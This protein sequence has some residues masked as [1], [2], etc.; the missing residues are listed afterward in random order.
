LKDVF[1]QYG[2]IYEKSNILF[3]DEGQYHSKVNNEENYLK[4]TSSWTFDGSY[5]RDKNI[6]TMFCSLLNHLGPRPNMRIG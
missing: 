5:E 2:D 1:I 6:K 3:I 4:M